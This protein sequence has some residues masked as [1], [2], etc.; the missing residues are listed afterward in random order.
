M[1]KGGQDVEKARINGAKGGRPSRQA[2]PK[3]YLDH[4]EV[5]TEMVT[6]TIQECA[7]GYQTNVVGDLARHR[8]AT[9][10]GAIS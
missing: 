3:T 1:I 10:C 2:Q 7:C 6:D 8:K 4:G 5:K 9:E